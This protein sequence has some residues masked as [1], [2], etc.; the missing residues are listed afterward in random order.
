VNWV[1]DEVG[2]RLE[3]VRRSPKQ[4]VMEE[5]LAQTR[6][7]LREGASTIEGGSGRNGRG[8]TLPAF[9]AFVAF[10]VDG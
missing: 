1:W 2:A 6:Q 7:H 3:V 4:E 10:V 9:I 5:A 8:D